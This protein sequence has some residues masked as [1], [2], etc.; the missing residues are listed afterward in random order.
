MKKL[1]VCLMMLSFLAV[2]ISGNTTI[3]KDN[4]AAGV[5]ILGT[6]QGKNKIELSEKGSNE[7]DDATDD[8]EDRMDGDSDSNSND[9]SDGDNAGNTSLLV[10]VGA[11][12]F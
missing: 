4:P 8:G 3:F 5:K 7:D 9:D 12:K 10:P 2:P 1:M 11:S 6:F